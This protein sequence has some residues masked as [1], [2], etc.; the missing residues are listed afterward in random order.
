MTARHMIAFAAAAMILAGCSDSGTKA[1]AEVPAPATAPQQPAAPA[2][3]PAA[4]APQPAAAPAAQP[5]APAPQPAAAPAAPAP[6]PSAEK[7]ELI[8]QRETLKPRYDEL[9]KV[10][11]AARDP[12]RAKNTEL[13]AAQTANNPTLVASIEADIAKLRPALDQAR[14]DF[15]PVQKEWKRLS[16]E[17]KKLP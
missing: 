3:Q 17:I 1:E 8:K 14:K 10:F 9:R 12:V 2:V 5:M 4:P 6:A 13:K 15:A 11:A 7:A 16:D